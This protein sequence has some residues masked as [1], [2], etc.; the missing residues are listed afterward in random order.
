MDFDFIKTLNNIFLRDAEFIVIEYIPRLLT[1]FKIFENRILHPFSG[2]S[3]MFP[4]D[5]RVYF[6]VMNSF[7]FGV[8]QMRKRLFL[9][10][11]KKKYGFV[12]IPPNVDVFNDLTVGNII[13]G[14]SEI[15]SFTKILKND[16]KPKHSEKRIIGFSKLKPGDSY[17]GTQNNKRLDPTKVCPVITSSKTRHVHPYEPRTLTVRECATFQGFPIDFEFFGKETASLDLIGKT[18]P[19]PVFEEIGKQI[20]TC[21]EEFNR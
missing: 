14:L 7:D 5:Y 18:V 16:E 4:D 21:I 8:P 11:S 13:K 1:Y 10:F 15:K 6:E 17:Y 3:L 2:E 19:P 12:F 20:K 9:I